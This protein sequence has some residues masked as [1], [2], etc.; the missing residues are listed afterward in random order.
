M[1]NN[2]RPYLTYFLLYYKNYNIKRG[3]FLDFSITIFK[4]CKVEHSLKLKNNSLTDDW[5]Y[6]IDFEK[7]V[8]FITGEPAIPQ[9]TLGGTT[10]GQIIDCK[11]ILQRKSRI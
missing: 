11:D 5:R 3:E 4:N 1:I 6:N 10:S 8:K 2:R 9:L 7:T